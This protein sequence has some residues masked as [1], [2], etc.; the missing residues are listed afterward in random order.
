M[1]PVDEQSR[2]A[3]YDG[4]SR[5]G[6]GRA[7]YLHDRYR[8]APDAK[9]TYP[10]VSSWEY[11]WKVGDEMPA[12]GRPRHARTAIVRDSFFTRNGV[13]LPCTANPDAVTV[14]HGVRPVD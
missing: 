4:F 14:M 12:Y 2:S 7:R 5:E 9:F 6:R 13:A 8:H 1:R 11:G 3:L 10:L